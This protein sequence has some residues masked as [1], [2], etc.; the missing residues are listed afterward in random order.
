[1][2]AVAMTAI[3]TGA[4]NAQEV[5]VGGKGFTEQQLIAEMT[6]QL[7]AANGIKPDKCVGMGSAVLRQVLESGQIDVCW[8]YTGTVFFIATTATEKYT[9]EQGYEKIRSLDAAKGIVWLKPTR[10]NNTYAI[11]MLRSKS[12]ALGIKSISDLGNAYKGGKNIM[13]GTNA[14]FAARPDGLPGVQ[15]T[16]GF[17]VPLDSIVKM[18]F[19]LSFQ[20]LRDS[21]V[22]AAMVTSTD[23]RIIA[24]DVLVLND[25]KAFFPIY[26]MTP[27][28]RKE[29]LDKN[30]KL[31]GL[32]ESLAAKLDSDTILKLN[33]AVDV[34]KKSVESVA[35]GFLKQQGLIKG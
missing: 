5:V 19:G 1:L 2:I 12:S 33:A 8:E 11:G 21:Q 35:N 4:V 27:V 7:L 22:E 34:D 20:A 23:G 14:E 9:A 31:A 6:S 18:D 26:L 10:V 17:T 29:A 28:A 13:I 25:D 32:L 30:P 24:F 3:A 15:K 16:Y